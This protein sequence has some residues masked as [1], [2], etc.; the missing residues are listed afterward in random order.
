MEVLPR[1]DEKGEERRRR[2]QK[3]KPVRE[4]ITEGSPGRCEKRA[5]RRR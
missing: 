1:F 5:L 4:K 3:R 2:G